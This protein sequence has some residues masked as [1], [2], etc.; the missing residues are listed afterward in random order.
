MRRSP[1]P[2]ERLAGPPP[3]QAQTLDRESYGRLFDEAYPAL[4]LVASVEVGRSDADDVVQ[5][6]SIVALE[7]LDRFEAGT[8]FKAWMAAIVRG[9]ARNH[10]RGERRRS[11]RQRSVARPD[12][13]GTSESP[14]ELG[15]RPGDGAPE[16]EIPSTFPKKIRNAIE[17]LGPRER[18]CF[19]LKSGAG[20]SYREIAAILDLPE[21]TARSHVHRARKRLLD[22][23][24]TD[25]EH[26]TEA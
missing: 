6:A 19:L 16:V 7:R 17:A 14:A 15:V 5:Q 9:V 4:R 10:R 25:R 12:V 18:A 26:E 13:A 24:E 2:T 20:L 21:A 22:T 11:D 1:E 3:G 8:D 23:L